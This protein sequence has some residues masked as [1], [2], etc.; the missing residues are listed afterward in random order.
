MAAYVSEKARHGS[1]DG[2]QWGE[3]EAASEADVSCEETLYLHLL[4]Q[5]AHGALGDIRTKPL[6]PNLSCTYFFKQSCR[7]LLHWIP[8]VWV[9]RS[10]GSWAADTAG[11][12]QALGPAAMLSS[13]VGW[14]KL[15]LLVEQA[16]G[17]DNEPTPSEWS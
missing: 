4:V 15:K 1:E 17:A 16:T 8:L 11:A 3:A 7:S 5:T 12:L 6:A 9:A 13:V 2:Q 14:A 10:R